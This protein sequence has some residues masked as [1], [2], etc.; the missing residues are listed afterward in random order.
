MTHRWNHERW[1]YDYQS[2]D[3]PKE[4][5]AAGFAVNERG[6]P[7]YPGNSGNIVATKKA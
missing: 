5:A 7:A 4:L 2:V 6:S 3:F 1:M